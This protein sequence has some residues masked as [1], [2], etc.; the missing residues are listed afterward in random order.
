VVSI[1]AGVL[2]IKDTI[3]ERGKVYKIQVYGTIPASLAD[4]IK[5]EIIFDAMVIDIKQ[6]IG[7]NNYCLPSDLNYNFDLTDLKKSKIII[8][9]TSFKNDYTGIICE[10]AV[11]GLA[12]IDTICNI[13]PVSMLF[14]NDSIPGFNFIKGIIK[15][16]SVPVEPKYIESLGQNYPNPYFDNTTFPFTIDKETSVNFKLYSLNGRR[17]NEKS[18]LGDV[19]QI[20]VYDENEKTVDKP[21]TYRFIRGSYK[22]KLTP[23]NSELSAGVYFL[24]MKT[25]YGVYRM[26]FIYIK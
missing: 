15:V 21:D 5:I 26:N 7:N 18:D 12:G 8:T 1:S 25:E 2:E 4:N 14:D 20:T 9:S 13:E 19:F 10:L 22:I 6:A 23:Y 3:V 24:I 17:L 16:N 11:E